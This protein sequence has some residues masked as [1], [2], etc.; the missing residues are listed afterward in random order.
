[1]L[2]SRVLVQIDAFL[3]LAAFLMQIWT[4]PFIRLHFAYL[5]EVEVGVSCR[6]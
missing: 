2:A 3:L 5:C 1:M 4:F 6:R